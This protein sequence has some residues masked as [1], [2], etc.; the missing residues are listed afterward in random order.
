M[1]LAV[2]T[3]AEAAVAV[4]ALA[5]VGT[6]VTAIL[7]HR[8]NKATEYNVKQLA[9]NGHGT[10]LAM[11]EETRAAVLRLDERVTMHDGALD[12]GSESFVELKAAT[13]DLKTAHVALDAKLDTAIEL[14]RA[15]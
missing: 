11:I 14:L 4:A 15:S 9:G 2:I 3:D 7:S 8:G 5:L 12:R 6:I 13:D 1:I 10:M